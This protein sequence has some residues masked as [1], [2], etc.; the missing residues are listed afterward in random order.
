MKKSLYTIIFLVINVGIFILP[1][2]VLGQF[3]YKKASDRITRVS[4]N[5]GN[6][7][8][9]KKSY[10]Q[11][12]KDLTEFLPRNYSVRGDIDYTEYLQ[13]GI[14]KYSKIIMPNF[15]ILINPTGLILKSNSNVFFQSNSKLIMKPNDKQLYSLILIENVRNVNIFYP[16]LEGDRYQHKS[17]KGEWGMGI[18]I[19]SS[20]NI[21]IIQPIVKRMWGD[22]IYIGNI[23]A[24]MP[25]DIRISSGVIDENR[26]NGI[27][28]ISGNNILIDNCTVSNTNGTAPEYGIDIEPNNSNEILSNIIISNCNTFNNKGGVLFALDKLVNIDSRPINIVLRNHTDNFSAKGI[29]FYMNRYNKARGSIN[30]DIIIENLTISN[31]KLPIFNNKSFSSKVLL[32]A[33]GLKLNG[34]VMSNSHLEN[35]GSSFNAG[36]EAGI[37]SDIN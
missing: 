6:E 20:S 35:F 27:S 32:K 17:T 29:E 24:V 2:N 18:F 31:S 11:N 28:I 30:G 8:G 25:K 22:G 7:V 34:K 15:P 16:N 26:R 21:N 23:G 37:K 10:F 9:I 14:D 13:R 19:R 33:K 3:R 5:R 4:T 1:L 36:I 12:A